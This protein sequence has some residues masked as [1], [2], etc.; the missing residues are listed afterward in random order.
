V[1]EFRDRGPGRPTPGGVSPQRLLAFLIAGAALAGLTA[2]L[3]VECAM[4]QQHARAY[5]SRSLPAE[6]EQRVL[7][8]KGPSDDYFPC[9]DCHEKEPTNRLVRPLEDDHE[10]IV[11]SHG[12]LWCL[13]CHDADDRNRLHLADGTRIEFAD[14]S[15]L[16]LQCHGQR[17][18]DWLTGVHGKRV[19]HWWG[20]RE[21]WTCVSCHSPHAPRFQPIEPLPPPKPPQQITLRSAR[22]A[23]DPHE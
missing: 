10:D 14:S 11:L 20:E 9:S 21:V 13:H 8:A 18:Q 3:S 6:P 7:P 22:S 1:D 5:A 2:L 19:G 4:G 17:R 16:C 15:Q 23:E 12:D